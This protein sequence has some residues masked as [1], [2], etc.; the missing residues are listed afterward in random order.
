[1]A[2]RRVFPLRVDEF[3]L[4]LTVTPVVTAVVGV[5]LDI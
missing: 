3:A 5:N 2:A 4:M 1:L